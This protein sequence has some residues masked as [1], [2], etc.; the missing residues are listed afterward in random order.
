[1]IDKYAIEDFLQFRKIDAKFCSS[2]DTKSFSRYSFKLG[3]TGKISAFEAV[4]REFGLLTNARSEPVLFVDF[5]SGLV[6]IDVITGELNSLSHNSL[7]TKAKEDISTLHIPV[8]LGQDYAGIL[9]T[10]DMVDLPHM[11]VG[12]TTGSGKSIFLHS[13]INTLLLSRSSNDINLFLIDP[14][15]VEFSC[16]DKSKYLARP[17]VTKSEDMQPALHSLLDIMNKRFDILNSIKARNISEYRE[18]R[19][20]PYLLVI[21][22]EVQDVLGKSNKLNE[23][24]ISTIAQK[25]RAAGIHLI[26]ATQH[27]SREILNPKIK[28]NFP[29]RVGFK[30][31][32]ATYSRVL[33][34]QSGAENLLGKGDGIFK[35]DN[36]FI[37][38][39]APLPD[40]ATMESKKGFWDIFK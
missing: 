22:D 34:D 40:I 18:R 25:G 11:L 24:I 23:D 2:I 20:I 10:V 14:K 30:T 4:L 7:L 15:K 36:L 8:I 37:R 1:M 6:N 21:I 17:I 33:L 13:V 32:N 5:Q 38:F 28:S 12:G 39:K 19:K 27:P 3:P 31:A 16:Y 9:H 29:A 35:R 26:L